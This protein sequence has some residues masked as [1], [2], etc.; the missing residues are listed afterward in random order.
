MICSVEKSY[1]P[2]KKLRKSTGAQNMHAPFFSFFFYFKVIKGAMSA[3]GHAQL[4][5]VR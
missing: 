1:F 5:S 3:G 4:A 2:A